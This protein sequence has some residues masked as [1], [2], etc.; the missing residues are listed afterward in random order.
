MNSLITSDRA[1]RHVICTE[2]FSNVMENSPSL[3]ASELRTSLQCSLITATC[4]DDGLFSVLFV[5]RLVYSWLSPL[6]KLV[7]CDSMKDVEGA[8]CRLRRNTV[9]CRY[10]IFYIARKLQQ[11]RCEIIWSKEANIIKPETAPRANRAS[12]N[13]PCMAISRSPLLFH[14]LHQ[15]TTLL[16]ITLLRVVSWLEVQYGVGRLVI[17]SLLERLVRGRLHDGAVC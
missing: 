17:I 6:G 7:N 2:P 3:R 14:V 12:R 5:V 16:T 1:H 4:R 13:Q 9:I 15:E 11:V 10:G 8:R